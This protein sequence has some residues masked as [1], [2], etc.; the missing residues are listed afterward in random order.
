MFE[1]DAE[2]LARLQAVATALIQHRVTSSLGELESAIAKWRA[3]ELAA[4]EAHGA[5]LRHAA[6]C[7]RTVDCVTTAVGDRPEGIIRDAFDA[8]LLNEAEV[9]ELVGRHPDQLVAAG[10]LNDEGGATSQGKDKRLAVEELLERGAVLIHVDARRD[11]VVV[12]PRLRGDPRLVLRFG[13][14][15]QPAIVDLA[16]DDDGI[17]G[18]LTFGGMPFYCRLRWPAVYAAIVDGEQRGTV[19]P[20][21]I[22]DVVMQK[23]PEPQSAQRDASTVTVPSRKRGGHL[24]LVD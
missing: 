1:R 12:P 19:W 2:T 16:V 7:E 6:R 11:D 3:G 24:T 20:E 4:L 9:V 15:L 13:Y 18:T 5:V 22:P 17:A 8:G 10:T 21:D 23:A 14:R